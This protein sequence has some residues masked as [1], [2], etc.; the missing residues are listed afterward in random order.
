MKLSDEVIKELNC[1]L[2]NSAKDDVVLLL[3][4]IS[5]QMGEGGY[6]CS[7]LKS[8]IYNCIYFLEYED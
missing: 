3:Q 7:D 8:I 1:I 6:N 5:K 2:D 4:K